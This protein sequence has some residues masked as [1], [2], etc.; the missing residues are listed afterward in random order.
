MKQHRQKSL[1]D[2]KR[3]KK[4]SKYLDFKEKFDPNS[5]KD[6]CEIIKDIIAMSNSGGGLIVFGVKNDSSPS[7]EDISAILKTDPAQITDKI[8]KYTGEQFDNF[9]IQEIDRNGH[10]TA[11]LQIGYNAIPLVFIQPGTYDI[12]YGKQGTAFSKGSVYFRHGAKSEPGNSKDLKESIEKEIE[13]IKKSWLGNIRKIVTSPPTYKA[14]MLP[15]EVK[16][17]DIASA[18]PIRIV[19]DLNAPAYRRIWD[20]SPY[21]TPEEILTGALKS[22]RRDKTSYASES[23]LWT[24]YACRGNLQ[25][26]EEKAECLLESSIN[27]HAPFFFWATF[28]SFDRIN[29]FIH[30]VATEGKYPAPNMVLKLAHAMGGKVGLQLLDYVGR[31]CGYPSVKSVVNSLKK[32]VESKDRLIRVYGAK[33]RIGTSSVSVEN[34]E[35]ADLEKSMDYAI[36]MKNKTEI[37]RI[38]ALLYGPELRIKKNNHA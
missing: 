18:F 10:K 34:A 22:W 2:V 14:V 29:D 1:E 28:L 27:R 26:D 15:P 21:Q 32:T 12:G 38:D 9:N 6:W 30:R 16:E 24:L 37:K 5:S 33:I 23:D 3:A 4:E 25:L 19:D 13:R 17:S 31:N 36:K 8:A 7:Q 20:D 35:R 11:V